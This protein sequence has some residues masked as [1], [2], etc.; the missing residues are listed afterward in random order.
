MAHMSQ[1]FLIGGAP[2][3]G[4]STA[5]LH[6]LALQPPMMAASTDAIRD[7]IRGVLEPEKHPILFKTALGAF[8]SPQ[9]MRLMRET[10]QSVI[11]HHV[12]EGQMTWKS[13]REFI[14]TNRNNERDIVVEGTA[15]LP[16]AAVTLPAGFRT[17][18]MVNLDDQAMAMKQHAKAHSY[19]WLNQYSDEFIDSFAHYLQALNQY[20]LDEA[21]RYGLS[22]VRVHNDTFA[23]D[24]HR[25]ALVLAGHAI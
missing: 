18:F 22:V 23:T 17:V 6:F 14:D 5:L 15:I 7:T 13:V 3:V 9:T 2:R 24:I 19:D 25:T 1:A 4:K 16:A 12:G 20:Y 8:D 10:P 21:D 11:Q